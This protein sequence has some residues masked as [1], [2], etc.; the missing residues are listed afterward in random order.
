VKFSIIGAGTFGTA[1][2]MIASRCGNEVLLWAHDPHVAEGIAKSG[3]N[4]SYLPSLPLDP[5]IRATHSLAEAAEFSDVMF[6]IVPSHHYRRVL[7]DLNVHLKAP[8]NVLSGT[9]GIENE[10]LNRMSQI[11]EEVLGDRLRAFAVLSGPT[12]A[13]EAARGDP[14]AAVVASADAEFSQ[15]MQR[16][17]SST[18]FRLYHA[19]DVAGVELAGSIKNVIAIAAGVVEGLG[20]GFNTNAALI[21]RGLYEISKLGIALGGR[22]E[23]FSGLAG[24]GDLVLTCTGS[25]SR[26]RTVGVALGQ[27]KKLHDI[28]DESRFVAE[29]VKTARA[30]KQLADRHSIEMPITAEMYRV[31]YEGESPPVAIQRLMSRSLKAESRD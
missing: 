13:I 5:K 22:P 17:L 27:G 16:A 14:T 15:S 30:A 28:L 4:P 21:T 20:L 24:M 7:T 3:R 31:L 23:T 25:L 19:T 10:T 9:K 18:T 12:F 8:V 26:N 2:A 6:M 29:G 1:M 11:T